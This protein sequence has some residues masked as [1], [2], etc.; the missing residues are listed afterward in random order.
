MNHPLVS[1]CIPTFNHGKYLSQ[2]IDSVLAQTWPNIDI[3]VGDDC[4]TDGTAELM[5]NY[6]QREPRVHYIRN[7]SNLG[8]YFNAD[9]LLR[10]PQSDFIARL[11]ADDFIH[12]DF[13]KTL[14]ALLLQYPKAGF[15]HCAAQT[16]N[17]SGVTSEIRRLFR[18][19]DYQSSHS[20]LRGLAQGLKMCANMPVF[21]REALEEINFLEGTPKSG[22]DYFL[23]VRLADAGWGNAYS[24]KVLAYYRVGL[25]SQWTIERNLD[26]ATGLVQV[27]ECLEK[28]YARR[29]WR[30]DPIRR[31]RRESAVNLANGIYGRRGVTEDHERRAQS[32]LSELW[33]EYPDYKSLVLSRKTLWTDHFR[34]SLRPLKKLVKSCLCR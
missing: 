10:R 20:S 28:A 5:A 27:F 12:P 13:T 7:A 22:G 29:G 26:R 32:V 8:M 18:F 9:S 1:F 17:E 2:C 24:K 4:S 19:C 23:A 25:N 6:A 21:R 11:D 34:E 3:W 14:M 15:A 31:T 30:I 16:V 33:G